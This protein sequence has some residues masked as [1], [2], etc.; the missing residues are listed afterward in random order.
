MDRQPAILSALVVMATLFVSSSALG[1]GE[2]GKNATPR[3]QPTNSTTMSATTMP[4]TT[5]PAAMMSAANAADGTTPKYGIGVTPAVYLVNFLI[6]YIANPN[7][8]ANMPAYRA[9][10]PLSLSDC[11]Q[12]YPSGCPYS[13]FALDFSLRP[14]DDGAHQNRSCS[15]PAEC[16]TNPEWERLAPSVAT[17]AEQLNEPLGMERA[18]RIAQELN[19]DKTMIL[20]DEQWECT[21]GQPPRDDDRRIIFACLNALTNSNGN[22]NIPLSSYGLAISRADAQSGTRGGNVQSLCAPDAPCLDFNELF[23][24]RLQRIAAVCGWLDKWQRMRSET[25]LKRFIVEGGQC[26][27]QIGGTPTGECLAEP[28]CP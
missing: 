26:Q 17:R 16:R 13:E 5:M 18:N 3:A 11:L 1:A 4:A 24:G 21:I 22:T 7:E 25:P 28:V 6:M 8:A 2:A 15:L 14:F 23:T 12:T 19:V 20:T 27:S 10:M 9:P